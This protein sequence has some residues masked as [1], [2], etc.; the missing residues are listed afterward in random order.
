MPTHLPLGS[1]KTSTR[2]ALCR[3]LAIA[4]LLVWTAPAPAWSQDSPASEATQEA[5]EALRVRVEALRE[6]GA[7]AAAGNVRLRR[8]QAVVRFFEARGFR[9]AWTDLDGLRAVRGVLAAAEAEGLAPEDY[10]VV[11]LDRRLAEAGGASGLASDV[12]LQLVATDAV[13]AYIDEVRYGRVRPLSLDSRWNVDPR[14]A[15]P[16]LETLVRLVAEASSP[17]EALAGFA[18]NHFIYQGL[19]GALAS[20]RAMEERG[21]WPTVPAGPT[22]KPGDTHARVAA[23]RQRLAVTGE[24][25][26]ALAD[27]GPAYDA[28][29]EAAVKL[30]QERHRLTPDAAIGRATI[31]AMNVPV[32]GRIAQVRANLERA[33]WVVGDLADSF[34][35]VNLPAYK[36]YLIRDGKNVWETRTQI[37]RAARQTPSFRADMRYLVFNPDWTVP[38]TILAQD[39]LAGMKK[40]QNTIK[41]KGLTILDRQGRAVDPASI[42]WASAS[43]SNFPY[44]LRQPPGDDNA[45]GRVKFIF[46]NEHAI[47]LHDTPS[48]RLFTTDERLFSS[49]CIRV[50]NPLD[51]AERLLGGQGDWTREAIDGAVAS[52]KQQTVYLDEPLPVLIVYWT[53][54]VGASGELRYMRDVYGLDAPLVRA[55]EGGARRASR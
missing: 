33:R 34:V 30:F 44:T 1:L 52:G 21:G 8:P 19:K 55:L 48:R 16:P 3:F 49:G 7:S 17:G 42:D 15:A 2:Q 25:D 46:P 35:L 11:T 51:L 47:F 54:S 5:Q 31:A 23:V 32:A 14:A 18:P 27:A 53:V 40:G 13:A 6:A 50:E 37:G 29:L 45:L 10:H 36:V 26:A 41:Q 12:A 9:P 39:V 24:L 20:L 38:P 4:V 43:A 22:L 28:P